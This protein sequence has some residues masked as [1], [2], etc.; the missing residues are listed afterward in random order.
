[1]ARPLQRRGVNTPV[2]IL[3][4]GR[5]SRLGAASAGLPK[6]LVSLAGRTLLDWQ[7]A[8]LDVLGIRRRYLVLGHAAECVATR[9]DERAVINPAWESCGPIGSLL[10]VPESVLAAGFILVYGDCPFHPDWLAALDRHPGDLAITAD[11]DWRALWSLRFADVLAD[12]ESLRFAGDRIAAIGGR[13]GALDEIEGQFT[14]LV[15]VSARG[16]TWVRAELEAMPADERCRLDTTTLLARLVAAGRRL[17]AVRIA[18]RWCEVDSASDLA[19][20]R[21]MLDGGGSWSHDCSM[22]AWRTCSRRRS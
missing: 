15:R 20:Y 1:L 17:D 7:R 8:A 11:L 9:R 19:L 6:C 22:L 12:A 10:C 18:G 21:A 5:G 16:W 13:A 14:G 4:A 2:V 3:A